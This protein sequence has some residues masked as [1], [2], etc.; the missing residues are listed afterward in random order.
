MAEPLL[1]VSHL[2]NLCPEVGEDPEEVLPPV[3]DT[4]VS[5]PGTAL[6]LHEGREVLHF[7]IAQRDEGIDV[8]PVEGIVRS[9]E[10]LDVLR[11]HRLT[12]KARRLQ[13]LCPGP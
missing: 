10:R 12:P 3:S 7:G 5:P 11:R 4:V 2:V 8:T 1:E 6:Q 9:V 13:G